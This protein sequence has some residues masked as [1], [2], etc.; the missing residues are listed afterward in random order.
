MKKKMTIEV[1]AHFNRVKSEDN[2]DPE[3]DITEDAEDEFIRL[4]FDAIE[5]YVTEV[6]AL[7]R[8][9]I[10]NLEDAEWWCPQ[11]DEFNKLG[12]INIRLRREF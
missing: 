1:E 5:G 7:V 6:E 10:F 3:Y 8:E 4:V 11:V 12:K 2:D 9:V